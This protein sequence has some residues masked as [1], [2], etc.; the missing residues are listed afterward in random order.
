M[1]GKIPPPWLNIAR[2]TKIGRQNAKRARLVRKG[3]A[4]K[5]KAELRALAAE[6]APRKAS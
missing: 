5:N 6:L 2:R 4:P 1:G 3:L